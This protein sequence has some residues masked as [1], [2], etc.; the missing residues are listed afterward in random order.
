MNNN[1]VA[2]LARILFALCLLVFTFFH[3]TK[4]NGMAGM[5]PSYLPGGAIWVYISGAG[6][7]LAA[8][9]FILNIKVKLAGYLLGAMFLI[10]VLTIHLPRAISSGDLSMVLKDTAMAAAAFFI[11]SKS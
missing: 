5:L 7:A 11:G 9:A 4:A 10:F 8:I 1:Q 3:F 2:T 6:L